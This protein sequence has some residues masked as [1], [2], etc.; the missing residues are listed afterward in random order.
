MAGLFAQTLQESYQ[1]L[2]ITESD[3]GLLGGMTKICASNNTAVTDSVLFLG[4]AESQSSPWMKLIPTSNNTKIFSIESKT[5]AS[6]AS[7]PSE[8]A[9]V[10]YHAAQGIYNGYSRHAS[11]M[12]IDMGDNT[13]GASKGQI[14]FGTEDPGAN[15]DS[16]SKT[17]GGY[18]AIL[19][20]ASTTNIEFRLHGD[21]P[22]N[23]WHIDRLKIKSSV[24]VAPV[25]DATAVTTAN[26]AG[27]KAS[28]DI[29][30]SGTLKS[31]D[32]TRLH[33]SN[34]GVIKGGNE[35]QITDTDTIT[36]SAN[37]NAAAAEVKID[38]VQTDGQAQTPVINIGTINTQGSYD[39]GKAHDGSGGSQVTVSGS[40]NINIGTSTVGSSNNTQTTTFGSKVND[41]SSGW[42][43]MSIMAESADAATDGPASSNVDTGEASIYMVTENTSVTK[44]KWFDGRDDTAY[45]ID[46]WNET[47]GRKIWVP[48]SSSTPSTPGD[49]LGVKIYVKDKMLR[50]L[51]LDGST[52]REFRL[53]LESSGSNATWDQSNTAGA[54]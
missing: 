8:D 19:G 37:N 20:D 3:D 52:T 28:A 47:A 49:D 17:W 10:R 36:I 43:K 38:A 48:K 35:V 40:K 21:T 23:H 6:P 12:V 11:P 9:I 46:S 25:F 1:K 2:I 41:F 15:V 22:S 24:G 44:L 33:S 30:A 50:I 4:T 31:A 42:F 7:A 29:D 32:F 16:T 39:T 5:N 13:Q 18:G 54:N 34:I 26:F 27:I 51:Y 53:D 14:I 45:Y